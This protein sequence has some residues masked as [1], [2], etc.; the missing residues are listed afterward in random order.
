MIEF[1]VKSKKQYISVNIRDSPRRI[2][3]AG[4]EAD[5]VTIG[6][7]AKYNQQLQSIK[8]N[9]KAFDQ[10]YNGKDNDDFVNGQ[11]CLK[12]IDPDHLGSSSYITNLD[13]EVSKHIEYVP[14]REVF[15][16]E[17]NN[18]WN[19]PYL[20]NA[21]EL[22]EETGMYCYGARYYE[23]R[24]SLW[25]SVDPRSEEAPEAS[26]YTY[27]HNAPIGRVDFDGKWDIKVSASSDRANHPYAIYAV[28]D[29]NGNLIY[30]TIVKV[31]GSY[32]KRNS[33]NAD[34]PQGKYKILGWKKTGTKRYPTISFGPN[35]LLALEYQ[36]GEG[37][38]RQGM[39]T[40]GGRRQKPDLM[41]THG[42]M[43]MADADIKELKE[44]V[45]QL[46]KNDPNERKGFLT[47][48]DDLQVP[49]NNDRDKIKEEVN[50]MKSYELPEVVV[51]GHRTQKVEKNETEKGGTKHETEQ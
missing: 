37:G 3:Y 11:V 47:L 25:M 29:R 42:C 45:T 15:I 20:F 7:K 49:V 48:K 43:R 10:P 23:P 18:A 6:Y 22:D 19:T 17:R 50:E 36:G 24:L 32:R 13:G 35:D 27:S 51:I 2:P 44:I 4:N 12:D 1:E 30:K 41:G 39:H 14:F 40:H 34:T 5:G 9:Y 38:Y 31:L 46:E 26:S 16:E 21:K 8:D 33:S 28:Y